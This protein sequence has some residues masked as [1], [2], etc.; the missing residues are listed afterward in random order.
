ME[1]GKYSFPRRQGKRLADKE[2]VGRQTICQGELVMVRFFSLN[3]HIGCVK[4]VSPF[5]N[6]EANDSQIDRLQYEQ[7][8]QTSEATG[9]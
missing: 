5:G 9:N 3:L 4:P 6:V 8:W 1:E 2:S 7:H